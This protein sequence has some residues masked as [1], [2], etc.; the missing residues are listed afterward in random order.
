MLT[1]AFYTHDAVTAVPTAVLCCDAAFVV[2]VVVAA[3]ETTPLHT[4]NAGILLLS[5]VPTIG[6]VNVGC[7]YTIELYVKFGECINRHWISSEAQLSRSN[8]ID[9]SDLAI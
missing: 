5:A 8:E 6:A 3:A 1:A 9:L 4:N 2:V 7:D